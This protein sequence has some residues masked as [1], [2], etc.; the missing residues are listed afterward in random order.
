MVIFFLNILRISTSNVLNTFLNIKPGSH[1][2]DKHKRRNKH[3]GGMFTHV[4]QAK[5][6]RKY[7]R[8]KW[9]WTDDDNRVVY[10]CFPDVRTGETSKIKISTITR[11]R[12]MLLLYLFHACSHWDFP[13]LV[14]VLI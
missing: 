5:E 11:K 14:L 9:S 2:L 13:V 1:L 3:K 8:A 12:K 6:N 7:A 10:T 4:R